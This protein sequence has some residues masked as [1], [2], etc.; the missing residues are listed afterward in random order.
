MPN[1]KEDA[2]T[3]SLADQTVIASREA[4]RSPVAQRLNNVPVQH[5][6]SLRI[7]GRLCTADSK[8]VDHDVSDHRVAQRP[9]C[10]PWALTTNDTPGRIARTRR[11]REAGIS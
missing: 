10:R 5:S 7:A 1:L 9:V 3:E 4:R 8:V 6:R 2:S 11:R